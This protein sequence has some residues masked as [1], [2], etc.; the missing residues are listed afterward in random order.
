MPDEWIQA[1]KDLTLTTTLIGIVWA[2]LKRI[3]IPAETVDE[4]KMQ[5]QSVIDDLKDDRDKD[6]A[7]LE[8]ERDAAVVT[9]RESIHAFDQALELI[10]ERRPTS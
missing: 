2:F 5:M 8:R 6:I 1:T 9:M 10:R 3:I 7:K 4:M